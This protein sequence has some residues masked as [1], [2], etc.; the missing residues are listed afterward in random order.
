MTTTL[1]ILLLVAATAAITVMLLALTY[2]EIFA[3]L[4]KFFWRGIRH[5]LG[6]PVLTPAQE[7]AKIKAKKLAPHMVLVS[8]IELLTPGQM[9]RYK[10][11]E[12]DGGGFID[13]EINPQYPL[14]GRKYVFAI[15][16][17]VNGMPS[18]HRSILYDSDKPTDLTT[19]ILDRHAELY[20]VSKGTP[21]SV[22]K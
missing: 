1:V 18:G 8:Q 17:A 9:L 22:P 13:I 20:G 19:S 12:T 6:K 5:A 4:G 16:K 11:P 21:V 15:E 3:R 14:G 2:P 10:I 7:E